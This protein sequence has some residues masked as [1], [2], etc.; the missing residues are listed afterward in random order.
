DFC[1]LCVDNGTR[2]IAL[3]DRIDTGQEGRE[4]SAFISTWHHERSNRDT[5]HRIRRSLRNRFQQGGVFQCP[6]YGY[7]KPTYAKHENELK[8]GPAGEPVYA[9]W[10]RRWEGGTTYS[11]IADWL[12]QQGIAPGPYSR[13]TTW[14]CAMVSR[15]THN[16][17]LKGLRVRNRMISRRVHKT[18]R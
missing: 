9:E 8:T 5:S 1:E 3:N 7:I 11:E 4:D 13:Q 17:I 18:G 2:L 15:V 10:F 12:N 6:I 16:P 14:S